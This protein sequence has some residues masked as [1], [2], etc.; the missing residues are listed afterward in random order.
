MSSHMLTDEQ[1]QEI[2]DWLFTES[3]LKNGDHWR[4]IRNFLG[5]EYTD[6]KHYSASEGEIKEAVKFTVRNYYN[7]N[8]LAQCTRYGEIYDRNDKTEFTPK[9]LFQ[10]KE[11]AVIR[12]LK[13]LHYQ[14]AEYLT[15]D[16]ALH[17]TLK[18]FI[19]ELCEN[20]FKRNE[21]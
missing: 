9:S 10:N 19:G 7:L 13:S 5:Y 17:K 3:V 1:Y 8:R 11:N 2:A 16:T 12:L 14:C 20:L 21:V 15:S 4:S 18:V 6:E